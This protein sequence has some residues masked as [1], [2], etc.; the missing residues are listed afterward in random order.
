MNDLV[1]TPVIILITGSAFTKII[2]NTPD[3]QKQLVECFKQ[4]NDKFNYNSPN[5]SVRT[6]NTRKESSE[7]GR[8]CIEK[9][10]YIKKVNNMID[11]YKKGNLNDL[12]S[13]KRIRNELQIEYYYNNELN[14]IKSGNFHE[15]WN[16]I[17]SYDDAPQCGAIY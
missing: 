3:T 2:I 1:S 17:K 13:Q 10:I 14:T 9:C 6:L 5:G 7:L 4:E 8:K 12:E 16:T 15:L 11:E